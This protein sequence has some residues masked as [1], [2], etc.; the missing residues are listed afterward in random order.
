MNA[1]RC[2]RRRLNRR[3][4]SRFGGLLWWPCDR[5]LI[6]GTWSQRAKRLKPPPGG[7]CGGVFSRPRGKERVF[8][9]NL[10]TNRAAGSTCAGTR[11]DPAASARSVS[12]RAAPP[13]HPGL[14]QQGE[15]D[16]SGRHLAR[17]RGRLNL[18]RTNATVVV[19]CHKSAADCSAVSQQGVSMF[20]VRYVRGCIS[21]RGVT[22][23]C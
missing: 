22:C 13:S 12:L 10:G 16:T 5:G 11:T 8:S 20:R 1:H 19:G 9:D 3:H 21:S 6:T 15:R 14:R 7:A 23:V 2:V 4:R 17:R 18:R